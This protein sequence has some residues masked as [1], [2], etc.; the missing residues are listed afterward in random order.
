MII[1]AS[2]I[3]PITNA[4]SDYIKEEEIIGFFKFVRFY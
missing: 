4:K 1:G 2:K 3:I